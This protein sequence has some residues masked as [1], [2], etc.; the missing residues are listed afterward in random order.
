LAREAA[1]PRVAAADYRDGSEGAPDAH[2]MCGLTE[3]ALE[4]WRPAALVLDLSELQY[5]WGDEMDLVLSVGQRQHVPSAVVIG[6]GCSRAIAT[7]F[8]GTDTSRLATEAENIFTDLDAAW[9]HVRK[10]A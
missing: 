2:F 9:K 4:I 3:I 10:T 6:P 8:W 7:L 1:N 5:D